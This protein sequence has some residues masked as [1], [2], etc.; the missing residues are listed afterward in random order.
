MVPETRRN[1]FHDAP[2]R[3]AV[4]AGV[5]GE[6][7]WLEEIVVDAHM[8]IVTAAPAITGKLVIV[9][10]CL[11]PVGHPVLVGFG[12]SIKVR[13]QASSYEVVT[14]DVSPTI[15]VGWAMCLKICL[16][17]WFECGMY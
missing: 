10:A 14:L 15:P 2:N 13:P 1:L 4:S 12:Q 7:D 17:M 6:T 16:A 3:R 11:W 9:T 8:V 5:Q